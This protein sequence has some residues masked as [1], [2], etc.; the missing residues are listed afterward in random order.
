MKA[1]QVRNRTF[2]Q[3]KVI[4]CK[5]PRLVASAT[6]HRSQGGNDLISFVRRELLLTDSRRRK[7]ELGRITM[8]ARD[9]A[10]QWSVQGID[11]VLMFT[12]NLNKQL[13][14]DRSHALSHVQDVLR[15][16]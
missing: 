14:A 16:I 15:E 5:S 12:S 6:K 3:T 7:A 13:Q 4:L 9:G 1:G 8:M 10:G 2:T 11:V